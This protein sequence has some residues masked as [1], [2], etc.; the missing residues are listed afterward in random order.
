[1][2]TFSN[3]VVLIT[4]ASSGI[5]AAVALHFATLDA[6][7]VLTGRNSENLN[8]IA[9]QCVGKINP[10]TVIGDLSIENDVK[11]IVE[12]AINHFGKLDVLVNNAGIRATGGIENTSLGDYDRV[13]GTN[14]RPVYQLTMLA[15]P[16]LIKTKGK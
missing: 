2:T 3:K 15:A 16:H 12:S 4:G 5:G 8:K 1:M 7:L 9:R 14:L 10:L 11:N 6:K 13:L